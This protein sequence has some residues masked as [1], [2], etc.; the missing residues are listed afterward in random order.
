MTIRTKLILSFAL[1]LVLTAILGGAALWETKR[2]SASQDLVVNDRLPKLIAVERIIIFETRIQQNIR[3][4]L[5]QTDAAERQKLLDRIAEYRKENADLRN[6]LKESI[7]SEQGKKLLADL[8]AANVNLV[9]ANNT[10]MQS[11]QNGDLESA[12]KAVVA[13]ENRERRLAQRKALRELVDYQKKLAQDSGA[14]GLKIAGQT[15]W[16]VGVILVA[17]LALGIFLV[18]YILRSVVRPINEM[19]GVMEDIVA[20]GDFK[21]QLEV[22]SQD[23]I[24][25]ALTSFNQMLKTLEES[26]EE[27]GEVVLALSQGDFSK[28][29]NG[30]YVGTLNEVKQGVN[31][32]VEQVANTMQELSKLMQSMSQGDFKAQFRADVKGEFR[33]MADNAMNTVTALDQI[34]S[35]VNDI[36]TQVV[37]GRFEGRVGA[38]A[39][40]DLATLKA[41]INSTLTNL[42]DVIGN[43]KEVLSA[44]AEGDFNQKVTVAC[45]GQLKELSESIEFTAGKVMQVVTQISQSTEVVSSAASE[46][47]QGSS[48]LSSRVQQQAA[49]LEETSATMDEMASTVTQNTENALQAAD[50]SQQAS[51]EAAQGMS[52]MKQ[53]IEAMNGIKESSH[54]IADIVTLIDGIAFQTNLLALNA[55]V[56][57]A[58]AGDH[59]RGF[60]VVAGEVRALAQKSAEAAKDIKTLIEESVDRVENGSRLAEDSGQ[61]LESITG[62]IHQVNEML[63]HIAQASEEQSTG[64]EQVNKAVTDIDQ[65]TQQNA[66]LVEESA[67]ASEELTEQADEMRMAVSFF[68]IEGMSHTH[69]AASL[70]KAPMAESKPEPKQETKPEPKPSTVLL[71]KVTATKAKAVE[72]PSVQED[73]GEWATF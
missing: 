16:V 63:G 44:Q 60:A 40:G 20:D 8:V 34:I 17:S 65:M 18:L 5:I 38:D 15:Q 11:V 28:R 9:E 43:I 12:A 59:G 71:E 54:K 27:T 45:E 7:T 70:A 13:P 47:A 53:T 64:V 73:D 55:A 52:V 68:K 24:G 48:D 36:M 37:Q 19:K 26:L 33:S 6:Y 22:S 30:D 35:E 39:Q 2:L 29:I 67:S 61:S 62:V 10:V 14:E 50:I 41:S 49:A 69:V 31:T 4:Y 57:A 58:R 46:L 51:K 56:E 3:E 32:S 72:K 25:L 66:A 1:M 21:R 42:E 23:E